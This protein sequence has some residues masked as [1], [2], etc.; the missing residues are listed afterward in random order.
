MKND[1]DGLIA[2]VNDGSTG[3][4]M[5]EWFT[6]KPYTMTGGDDDTGAVRFVRSCLCR[7]VAH[8]VDT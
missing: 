6:T 4:F 8:A 2:S 5:W 3:A 7:L 1:I